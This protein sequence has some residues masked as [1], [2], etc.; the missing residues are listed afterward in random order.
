MKNIEVNTRILGLIPKKYK[1]E[2]P[3]SWSEINPAQLIA[4]AK[5]YLHQDTQFNLLA[6][7]TGIP[8]CVIR[9]LS[10]LEIF[11]LLKEID[12]IKDFRPRN[13]FIIKELNGLYSPRPK[14]DGM[15]WGQFIFVDSYY[16]EFMGQQNDESLNVF[17]AHLYM[18]KNEAFD[19]SL[20]KSR[21]Q[22]RYIKGIPY[23]T[24]FA[25]SINYRLIRE[26]LAAIYPL[27]F[28]SSQQPEAKDEQP[29]A[30]DQRPKT[31]NQWLEIHKHLVGD[32]IIDYEK[33]TEKQLHVILSYLT[34]KIKQNARKKH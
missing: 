19:H 6:A 11:Y 31:K 26:W 8:L 17:I 33:Y 13:C 27:I 28:N 24:K 10:D 9:K 22:T 32:N 29:K 14:L 15:T 3:E 34:T 16:E 4:L 20:A 1:G 18:R 25:I 23:E 21:A 2:S 30:K 12:F 7:F 5:M